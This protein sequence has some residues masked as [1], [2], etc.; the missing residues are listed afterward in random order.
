MSQRNQLSAESRA[1]GSPKILTDVYQTSRVKRHATMIIF[2]GITTSNFTKCSKIHKA[3]IQFMQILRPRIRNWNGV[4]IRRLTKT[5][6]LE[7][8]PLSRQNNGE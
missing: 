7:E 3:Y 1:A 6:V 4:G 8:G 5:S 2:T